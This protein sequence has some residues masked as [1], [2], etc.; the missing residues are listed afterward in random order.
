MKLKIT[1]IMLLFGLLMP[2]IASAVTEDDFM[3]KT[4]QNIVNLCTATETDPQQKEAIHFCHG[5]LVGA[6]HYH[7]SEND[8]PEFE[9]QI[10][11][12]DHEP[13]RNVAIAKVISWMQQHPEYMNEP[14][15]EAA[16]RALHD[17]W[18]CKK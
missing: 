6:Y 3:A 2:A 17:L 8:G 10:C 15:V 13:S 9:Q 18:P 4:A 11:F 12:P 7:H 14:P 5:Y 1:K 16:F